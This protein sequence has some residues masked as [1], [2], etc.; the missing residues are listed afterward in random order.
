[1]RVW[2]LGG[3]ARRPFSEPENSHPLIPAESHRVDLEVDPAPAKPSDKTPALID[4][5][6]TAL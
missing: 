4:T 2:G 6:T 5:L 1:M 3:R